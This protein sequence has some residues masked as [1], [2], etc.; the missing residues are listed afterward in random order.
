MHPN[1][2]R[3]LLLQIG[4]FLTDQF[5]K[6]VSWDGE[7]NKWK[8]SIPLSA[9]FFHSCSEIYCIS[10][11]VLSRSIINQILNDEIW[12][13]K[14]C[15]HILFSCWT[16][17]WMALKWGHESNGWM[18]LNGGRVHVQVCW[19]YP[20]SFML[21]CLLWASESK[22]T[23]FQSACC[24]K[25]LLEFIKNIQDLRLCNIIVLHF[26][27]MQGLFSFASIPK[28]L[29]QWFWLVMPHPSSDLVTYE[30]IHSY[31]MPYIQLNWN[32]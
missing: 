7:K 25:L 12:H 1:Y 28:W 31:S 23:M 27:K 22:S 24:C 5:V 19:F 4:K 21:I 30:R 8:Q 13:R 3:D 32:V 6:Q 18:C 10:S 15:Q 16:K 29:L 17:Y 2:S 26:I 11:I 14:G 9:L 20:Q